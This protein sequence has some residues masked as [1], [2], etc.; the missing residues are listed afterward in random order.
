[1]S[2]RKPGS[3]G[4]RRRPAG[5]ERRVQASGPRIVLWHQIVIGLVLFGYY[6]LAD[7]L[8]SPARRALA[9]Q[10][11]RTIQRLEQWLHIDVEHTLNNWLA[12]HR[13]L[14]IIANYEYAFTYIASALA[15]LAFILW[16]HPEV[17]RRARTSFLLTTGVG[18]TCFWAF[19]TTPPRML[20]GNTYVD[21]VTQGHTVGSWGSPMVAG[22]NQLAAMP[23]LHMAWALWVSV[24]IAWA[25]IPRWVQL[26]SA[27]HV[28]VTLFV[29]LA[30]ANH[31]L[32]DA[33]A[34]A[35]IVVAADRVALRIHPPWEGSLVP[36]ADAFFLHVEDGGDPQIVGGLVYFEYAGPLPTRDDVRD[37]VESELPQ[38]PRFTQRID[39]P[40]RWRRPRWVA[41]PDLDWDWHVSDLTVADRDGVNA[42]V[43]ELTS[44]PMPRDRPLWRIVTFTVADTG[45]RGFLLLMHHAIADGI[46]TVLQAMQLLRPRIELPTPPRQPTALQAAAATALGFAQL[47]TDGGRPAPLGESS[48]RRAFATAGL[49]LDQ[50]KRAAAGGRV[51]DLVLALTAGAVADAHPELVAP[52]RGRLRVAVP[53]MVR[54]PSST[55]EGNAT[56]AVML[57]V[58][59]RVAPT[60]ELVAEIATRT[61]PLR[62]PTRALASRWVMAHLLRIFPEPTV[63]WFARTVYGGSFFSGIVSN[64]PGATQRLTMAGVALDEVYPILPLA[65]RAPFVLGGLSW[66]GVL[67]LGLATDPALVDA[68]AVAA[69]MVR[70]FEALTL[71]SS[72][73][74]AAASAPADRP[75]TLR[76]APGDAPVDS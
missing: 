47:A 11:G 71:T 22:A 56:A 44:R 75:V 18:I 20:P 42:A 43:A 13:A 28:L 51:T 3:A 62:R 25:G 57:D 59:L 24:A 76:T 10:H 2:E 74:E 9:D 68:E 1:M 34:A 65:P 15:A 60:E 36:S 63:G 16:R 66:N 17:Y 61:A 40:G 64:M 8:H 14:S 70:R 67:G 52:S 7:S 23:S 26:I 32:L 58:P 19:S 35:V 27:V 12:G 21:T 54:D 50:V 49:P 30:T 39:Q 46:G 38:L 37:L 6:L 72:A 53:L 55:Q 29:I 33:V 31:Y 45:Q 5:G 41:A 69:A 73:P 4:G 48:D